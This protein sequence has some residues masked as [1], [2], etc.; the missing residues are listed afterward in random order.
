MN[1]LKN[2]SDFF[3]NKDE[4]VAVYLFGSYA[5]GKQHHMSDIDLGIFFKEKSMSLHYP[6]I[7]KYFNS[8]SRLLRRD[9]HLVS[10][11]TDSEELL[12]QIFSKGQCILV[13]DKNKLVRFKMT[14]FSK[15]AD[16]GY[17]RQII[18]DGFIN[19]IMETNHGRS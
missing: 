14:A 8:L 16:F 15:I 13:N 11:N 4:V 12:K 7:D 2:I 3:K 19:K 17:Y 18:K 10:L 9:I 5:S 6:L 1:I